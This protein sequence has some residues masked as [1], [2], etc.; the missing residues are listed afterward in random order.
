MGDDDVDAEAVEEANRL[1]GTGA[2]HHR[3]TLASAVDE[4]LHR[5]LDPRRPVDVVH[6]RL[7]PAHSGAG[8]G[9]EEETLCVQRTNASEKSFWTS[10][11]AGPLKPGQVE[12]APSKAETR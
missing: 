7:G 1:V 5:V 9:G 3:H 11:E 2:E 12:T 6:Q 10:P 8:P 4:D